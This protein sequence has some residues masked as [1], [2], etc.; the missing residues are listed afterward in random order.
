MIPNTVLPLVAKLNAEKR[1]WL[2][3][4]VHSMDTCSVAK[5]LL[6]EWLPRNA[7]EAMAADMD[8]TQLV[9]I[10]QAAAMFHDIGKATAAFQTRITS[11]CL[12]LRQQL[13]SAGIPLLS[14][15]DKALLYSRK[16]P[17]AAAGMALMIIFQSLPR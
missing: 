7:R 6:T 4:W 15:H 10:V 1:E 14:D 16:L 2:P 12:P 11:G 5:R 3:L 17:H 13:M 9:Q 8:Q